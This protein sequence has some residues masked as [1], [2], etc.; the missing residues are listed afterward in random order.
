MYNAFIQN[1]MLS[2]VTTLAIGGPARYFIEVKEIEEMCQVLRF[3]KAEK[4]AYFVL[5]KG[6]NTLFLDSGFNGLVIVN[7]IDF[8][9]ESS[10]GFF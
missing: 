5:G 4:L 3:C 10:P 8:C 7:K 2:D 9:K 6:S 1:K